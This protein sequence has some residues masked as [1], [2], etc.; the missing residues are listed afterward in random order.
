M[1]TRDRVVEI[2]RA[3]LGLSDASKY[4]RDVLTS[5]PPYP[6]HWCGAFA[7]WCLRQA[8]LTD[9]HWEIGKGF[10]W[11]LR[12]TTEPQP[13]DIGYQDQPFQH[14][15]VVADVGQHTIASIDGNQGSPG[16]QE[17]H[18]ALSNPGL[19]FFSIEPLLLPEGGF[20]R[21]QKYSVPGI[22]DPQ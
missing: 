2:A 4:W 11:R 14:H 9:W 7:L 10:L 15:F 1:T 5:G 21:G 22:E 16:V 6:P 3:E 18:R 12:R 17:R 19:V 13:G 20:V 8:G